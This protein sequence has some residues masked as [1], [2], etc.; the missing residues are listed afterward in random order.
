[1]NVPTPVGAGLVRTLVRILCLASLGT[2]ASGFAGEPLKVEG[3]TVELPEFRVTESRALPDPEPWSYTRL[4]RFEVLS[5]ASEGRTRR[6]LAEFQRFQQALNLLWPTQ[7]K[8]LASSALVLCGRDA[9]F[10]PFRRADSPGN[11]GAIPSRFLQNRESMAI[12][13]NLAAERTLVSDSATSAAT[14]AASVELEFDHATL[15][16]REYLFFLLNQFETKAP[17]WM[18]EGLAQIVMDAEV[19]DGWLI[20]GKIDTFKGSAVG[21]AISAE[22]TDASANTTAVV[23][24]QPFNAVLKNRRLIP[25]E[26]FLAIGADS[27]EARA[28]LGN[29]LWAKQAYLFVHFC[30][31]GEDLRHRE[32]LAEFVRRLGREPLSEQLFKECFKIGYAQ[33]EDELRAYLAHV[34][35]KF[36]RYDLSKSEQVNAAGIELNSASPGQIGLILGD[37][38]RL[39]NQPEAGG[40]AYRAGYVRGGRDP[41]LL[42]G[43]AATEAAAGHADRSA[44]FLEAACTAGVAR[45]SAHAALARL[46]LEQAL[47]KPASPDGRLDVAQM[48]G[49]LKAAFTARQHPPALPETYEVIADAW[50]ASAVAP[51]PGNLGVLDEGVRAFPRHSALLLKTAKLYAGI[52]ATDVATSIAKLGLRFPRDAEAAA[53]FER[54]L[55]TLPAKPAVK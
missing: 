8:P 36:Q 10:E 37:A 6:L 29:N 11:P 20:Y 30:T 38:L 52:G 45:P 27:E 2:A 28:P 48:G 33:M 42:A 22:E 40:I 44:K 53:E 5:S 19:T 50:A 18:A 3:K 25:L 16:Y 21:G 23:G 49:V 15:L 39:A 55:Q 14:E 54:F 43:L 24:E 31:F 34:R 35:H 26:R 46:R 17:A 51:K 12:V 32:H 7:T 47:A 13:V 9:Q 1:M 41:A 4:G